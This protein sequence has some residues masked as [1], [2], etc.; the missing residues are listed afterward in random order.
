MVDWYEVKEGDEYAHVRASNTRTAFD[1]GFIA[2]CGRDYKLRP[3]EVMTIHVIRLRGST[4]KVKT[5]EQ[6]Y[7]ES[8]KKKG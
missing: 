8:R 2:T 1:K 3:G 6:A 5:L 4:E 7:Q